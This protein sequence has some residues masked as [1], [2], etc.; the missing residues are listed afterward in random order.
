MPSTGAPDIQ[1][2]FGL[3]YSALT[4]VVFLAPGAV[5]LV[6]EPVMFL[7][8]DRYPR[9]WFVAGGLAAMA[10]A[11]FSA[12]MAPGPIT[13]ALSIAVWGIATG[14]ATSL[15]QATLVDR[16]PEQRGRTMARWTIWSYVGDLIAPVLFAGL[17]SSQLGW[18]AAFA[19][20][21]GVLVACAIAVW[22]R[23]AELGVGAADGRDGDVTA[24]M[25]QR[26]RTAARDRVLLLWLFGTALCDL[27]DEIF[28]VFA[29]LHVRHELGA[30]SAWQGAVLVAFSAGGAL[31]LVALGRL[32]RHRGERQLLVAAAVACALAYVA[33][34]HAPT[35]WLSVALAGVVGATAA[36]LY[37]LAAAQAYA[38]CPGQSGLVLAA[39]HLFTPLGLALPFA[40]GLVADE[41]GTHV[42]L[43]ALLV[44][45]LGLAWLA[46]RPVTS[47]PR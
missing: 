1:R 37:P 19:I 30:G 35:L 39:S 7:L 16:Q 3:S 22:A 34:M 11:A 31:G 32:L 4:I 17:A 13:L 41:A 43:V 26:L 9:R 29:S 2:S 12:A 21:G 38:R 45:P 27:L 5:A 14:V 20:V 44:Q 6:V 28:V 33:W 46:R 24:P 40:I 36:P 23:G 10:L 8:A 25:W 47:S 42:A 15:A 18:R